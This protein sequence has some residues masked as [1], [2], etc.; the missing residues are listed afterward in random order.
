MEERHQRRSQLMLMSQTANELLASKCW[1]GSLIDG[2][3]EKQLHKRGS[4]VAQLSDLRV[5]LPPLTTFPASTLGLLPMSL[6][7]LL[8][9]HLE[10][11]IGGPQ[12]I[13]ICEEG[14]LLGNN[15]SR[16]V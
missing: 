14:K 12:G 2:T 6:L 1:R 7:A 4:I 8:F 15:I 5:F 10:K 16:S 9:A 3:P 11:N 13:A